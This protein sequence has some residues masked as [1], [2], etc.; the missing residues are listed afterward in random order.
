M[1]MDGCVQCALSKGYKMMLMRV[2][3]KNEKDKDL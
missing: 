3:L 2:I 1:V